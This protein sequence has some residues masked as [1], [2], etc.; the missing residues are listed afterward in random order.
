MMMMNMTKE[1]EVP[2]KMF[3]ALNS[4]SCYFFSEQHQH[5]TGLQ[6]YLRSSQT[7]MQS[8]IYKQLFWLVF[9]RI[10]DINCGKS[11]TGDFGHQLWKAYNAWLA[12]S[13]DKSK[14]NWGGKDSSCLHDCSNYEDGAAMVSSTS[15]ITDGHIYG[16]LYLTPLDLGCLQTLVTSSGC[17]LDINNNK[18]QLVAIPIWNQ[19]CIERQQQ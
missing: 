19:R 17:W 9:D 10:S 2:D 16:R 3:S 14:Q 1:L 5:R 7:P 18:L 6:D 12:S 11:P 8:E 15:T 13:K 4:E